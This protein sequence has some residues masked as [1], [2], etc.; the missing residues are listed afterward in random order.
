MRKVDQGDT[1][2][3]LGTVAGAAA[4]CR[5]EKVERIPRRR[6]RDEQKVNNYK[7][8]TFQLEE[9]DDKEEALDQ[10]NTQPRSLAPR[11][12]VQQGVLLR[13]CLPRVPSKLY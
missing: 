9:D 10:L 2:E 5:W 7:R 6:T 13:L 12:G 3:R 11:R 8:E 1:N 4:R